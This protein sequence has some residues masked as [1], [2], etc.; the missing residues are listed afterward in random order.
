VG[1]FLP[2]IIR[3]LGVSIRMTGFIAALPY[4]F[5]LGAML[6]WS[7]RSDRTGRR[8]R[9]AAAVCL[10]TGVALAV[11][12]LFGAGHPVLMIAAITVAVMSL[13]SFAP[14]FWPVPMAMLS[15]LAAAGGLGLINS[16]GNV[17]GLVGPWVFGLIKDATGGSDYLALLVISAA[18]VISAVILVA[19]GYDQRVKQAERP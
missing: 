15:G 4:V 1:L 7:V 5:G 6:W 17:S 3:A 13:Q 11:C 8:T 2:Q 9:Y 18:P 14:V 19:L 10:T 12:G 16:V